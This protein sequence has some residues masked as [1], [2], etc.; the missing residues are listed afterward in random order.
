MHQLFLRTTLALNLLF[1]TLTAASPG[2]NDIYNAALKSARTYDFAHAIDLLKQCVSTHTAFYPAVE[3]L[4]EFSAYRKD[5]PACRDFF[6]ARIQERP[7]TPLFYAGKALAAA[8]QADWAEAFRL[9]T[10]AVEH[11]ATHPQVLSELVEAAIRSRKTDRLP[12]ILKR[13]RKQEPQAHL[14]TLGY[15]IWRYKI[16]SLKKARKTALE[17]IKA[18]PKD[19]AGLMLLGDIA[20][21]SGDAQN[22][23]AAYLKAL[24]ARD[25]TDRRHVIGIYHNIAKVYQSLSEPDS[26]RTYLDQAIALAKATGAFDTLLQCYWEAARFYT[27]R[28]LLR[29]AKMAYR[30]SID[31]L[32]RIHPGSMKLAEAYWHL[33]SIHEQY[34]DFG[35]ALTYYARCLTA[36]D[37][38]K[39]RALKAKANLALGRLLYMRHQS[40][41]AQQYLE[42]A[43][44]A[45][46]SASDAATEHSALLLLAD[47][48][49]EKGDAAAAKKA[50][51]AVLRYSQRIQEHKLTDL[52]FVKLAHLYENDPQNVRTMNYYLRMANYLSLQ[53]FQLQFRANHSWIHGRLALAAEKTVTAETHFL[54]A[55]QLGKETGSYLARIAGEGGLIQT[56]LQANMP[57]LAVV[58]ADTALASL[59]EYYP[60]YYEENLS[61]FFDLKSDV[62]FPALTAY[63]AVGDLEKMFSTIELYKAITQLQAMRPV[64]YY[65]QSAETDS[66]FRKFDRTRQQ[67]KAKWREIWAL[68]GHDRKDQLST[69][70]T[71][72]K[73][74]QALHERRSRERRQLY[75][76]NPQIAALLNPT[77]MA[78][79]ALQEFLQRENSVFI[80]Y[81]VHENASFV[82]VVTPESANCKRINISKPYLES[83]VLQLSPMFADDHT[84]GSSAE[85]VYR[86][87]IAFQ[88]YQLLFEP[89]AAWLPKNATVIISGDDVVSRLPFEAFISNTDHLGDSYDYRHA[90]FLIEDYTFAYVPYAQL[91]LHS[92]PS[93][94]KGNYT[95]A[96]F[97]LSRTPAK[98]GASGGNGHDGTST[99]RL[100]REV[101][102]L[103]EHLNWEDA[104]FIDDDDNLKPNFLSL[105]ENSEVLH[106]NLPML[107]QD[108]SPLASTLSFNGT[109]PG[110]NS[111][112]TAEFFNMDLKA[113]LAVFTDL[114]RQYGASEESPGYNAVLQGLSF[115][116]TPGMIVNRWDTGGGAPYLFDKFYNYLSQGLNAS[117]ALRQ[118]KLDYIAT[119]NPHPYF[120]AAYTFHGYALPVPLPPGK[121]IALILYTTLALLLLLALIIGQYRQMRRDS[122][123]A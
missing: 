27:D 95:L 69:L 30:A 100:V 21:A 10:Q 74:I 48:F 12:R 93:K 43:A 16:R 28:D 84:N 123:P 14:Y 75:E 58:R 90:P 103:R 117:A 68:W 85:P 38:K 120:W 6:D 40:G 76:D 36:A 112:E 52:C 72:K 87:D 4:V 2:P 55:V 65:L 7:E 15:A 37:G 113:K 22:A 60:L 86:L 45:A 97:A 66:L 32:T 63:S 8:R 17:Y 89:V 115:A 122:E 11:G 88:L 49:Q 39:Q 29:Q 54:Q 91:L 35:N 80:H 79:A 67:I 82:L 81:L 13:L 77:L 119:V 102:F 116:G 70:L 121:H 98:A 107:V 111:F 56:Y 3:T 64:K 51:R 44:S 57:E 62:I 31:I 118:A 92:Q 94:E 99:R 23:R 33:G 24:Q 101:D 18:R 114:N 83:L 47:I 109:R 53:T 1:G 42:A 105:V 46:K 73:Q 61:P 26:A 20:K 19:A 108:D 59:V 71:T 5:L 104:V 25:T 50:L 34:R 78:P 96:A 110:D 106:V 41:K 9:Y